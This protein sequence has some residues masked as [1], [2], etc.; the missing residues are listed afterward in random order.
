M[1]LTACLFLIIYYFSYLWIL[2]NHPNLSLEF[3][4]RMA[5]FLLGY[6]RLTPVAAD[7]QQLD[8]GSKAPNVL[9]QAPVSAPGA[10]HRAASVSGVPET[11]LR[12]DNLPE[13]HAGLRKAVIFLIMICCGEDVDQNQQKEKGTWKQVQRKPV[14]SCQ[15]SPSGIS[16]VYTSF[17]LQSCMKTHTKYCKPGKL[18]KP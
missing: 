9:P 10:P 14:T 11:T 8:W 18:T 17:F 1:F 2:M 12:L 15:V 5:V 6:P 4:G 16:W 7:I 3:A 13:R